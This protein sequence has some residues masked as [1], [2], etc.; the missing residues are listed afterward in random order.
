MSTTVTILGFPILSFLIFF[1]LLGAAALLLIPSSKTVAIRWAAFAVSA[2][3][4]FAS[5]PLFTLFEGSIWAAVF[6]DRR[7]RLAEQRELA[8]EL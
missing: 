2:I 3:T 8:E 6:L 4:F 7:W 5:I 1:P